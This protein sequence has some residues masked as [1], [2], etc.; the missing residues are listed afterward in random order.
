MVMTSRRGSML[1]GCLVSL[2]F[3]VILVYLGMSAAEVALNYYRFKDAMQQ[4]VRFAQARSDDAI[5]RRLRN[6]ADSLDL[7]EGARRI[8]IAR[9]PSSIIVVAEYEDTI[10]V[11]WFRRVV[12]LRP[13]V[14]RQF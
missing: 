5:K 11:A 1:R 10:S 12:R 14:E 6:V 2:L 7:P 3:V 9:D 8:R 4:E 13:L